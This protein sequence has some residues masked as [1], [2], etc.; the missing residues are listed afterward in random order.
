MTTELTRISPAEAHAKMTNEGYRYVDVR[1]PEEFAAGHPTGAWNVPLTAGG[2]IADAV[3]QSFEKHD[4]IIVGCKSGIRSVT[5]AKALL[6]AG[7]TNVVEQRAGWDGARGAFG[8]I[9]EP[10][11]KRCGLPFTVTR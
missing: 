5:A 10:G 6:A 11:W 8:E 4:K 7:F 9:V 3:E 2:D 1:S